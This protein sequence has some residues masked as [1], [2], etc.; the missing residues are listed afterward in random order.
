MSPDAYIIRKKYYV[1][2][3]GELWSCNKTIKKLFDIETNREIFYILSYYGDDKTNDNFYGE[4][5]LHRR[6]WN[7][8]KN[9]YMID[10]SLHMVV[11]NN[12]EVF[13]EIDNYFYW[14]PDKMLIL[15]CK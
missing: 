4:L 11:E 9:E 5:Y 13:Q 8:I 14:N 3:D 10:K 12:K 6:K 2:K 7:L 15:D 1:D